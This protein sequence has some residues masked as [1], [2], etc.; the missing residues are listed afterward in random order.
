M[1]VASPP[2]SA[3]VNG[4]GMV[5]VSPVVIVVVEFLE[6]VALNENKGVKAV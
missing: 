5:A 6:A 4:V 2:V 3:G 1:A